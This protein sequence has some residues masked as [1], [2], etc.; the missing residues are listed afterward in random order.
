MAEI[1]VERKAGGIPWWAWLLG[2]LL[3]AA[4]LF[5]LLSD[6]EPRR[7]A[8]APVP[9]IV[10]ETVVPVAVPV[11]VPI[12]GAPAAAPVAAGTSQPTDPIT[13]LATILDATDRASLVGR[14][15]DV[16]NVRVLDVVGDRTFFVGTGPDR[17]AFVVLNEVPTPGR[18]GVEGRY[19]VN[20]GQTININ[21]IMR[22]P[23]EPAF[24]GRPIEDMPAGTDAL[25]HA[26]SL[27]IVR[28]P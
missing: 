22:S 18:P 21:G 15:V 19:D 17:R 13:D 24:A 16:R 25:I 10:T 8:A 11:A 20:A 9:V 27:D 14:P 12:S 1:R 2:A 5:W 6:N 4:L 26:Q 7:V 23:S 28:R 3:L